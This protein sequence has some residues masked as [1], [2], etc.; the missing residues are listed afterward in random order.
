[1]KGLFERSQA[2]ARENHDKWLKLS[3]RGN[4]LIAS[5]KERIAV[6]ESEASQAAAPIAEKSLST[7]ERESLLKLVIG[8]AIAGY[9]YDPKAERSPEVTEIANDLALAGVSLDADTVRKWLRAAAEL[10]PPK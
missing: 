10:L 4:E 3:D 6:L 8:M 1:M 2:N 5:L 9:R 7:R